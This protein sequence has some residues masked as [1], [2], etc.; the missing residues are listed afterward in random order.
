MMQKNQDHW[1]F[2]SNMTKYLVDTGFHFGEWLVPGREDHTGEQFGICKET[3]Y[4]I[5]P[6]FG[7]CTIKRC[8]KYLNVIEKKEN[9]LKYENLAHKIKISI[10][11][12]IMRQNLMPD[13][14]MGA[15]VLAFAFQLVPEDHARKSIKKN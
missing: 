2:Q 9:A 12:G 3:A 7:Y 14:L 15:Y 13:D 1:E 4:Y 11:E 5:A 6:F 10:Q 8:L